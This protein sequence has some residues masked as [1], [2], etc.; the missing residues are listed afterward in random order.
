[1]FFRIIL[2]VDDPRLGRKLQRV[3]RQPDMSA[4]LLS[5]D[6]SWEE[7]SRQ[8]ADLL[9]VS[10]S[11]LPQPAADFLRSFRQIP[12]AP[13]VVILSEEEKA[14]EHARFLAAGCAAVLTSV[15]NVEKMRG[16]FLA[17]LEKRRELTLQMLAPAIGTASARLTDFVTASPTMQR[18]MD[19]VQRVV[20]KDTSLLI[21]GE[22]GVG[23]E[24][25]ARAI[26]AESPRSAGPFITVNCGAIPETLL[27]SE[28]FG[29][30]EGAFTGAIRARRGWFEL[31]H[32]GTVFLDEIGEL[33]YHLQVKLLRALQDHE[34]Q[35]LGSEKVVK[36]DV[37]VI[38]ATNRDLAAELEQNRFRKDLYYRL[39]VVTLA[40]PPLRERR[41]DVPMLIESYLSHL[42]AKIGGQ[43]TGIANE[44]V[45]ALM[46]YSWP[47]NVRELIN[48]IE[49]AML[50][51][52][53][54]VITIEDLPQA[55]KIGPRRRYFSILS[56][57]GGKQAPE[58][59]EEALRKPLGEVREAFLAEVER[60][61]LAGLL[62]QTRGRVG[63][64]A[65]RAGNRPRSLYDKMKKL[66]LRKEDF[67][68]L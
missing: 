53:G 34:I 10:H 29:H 66:G 14:V 42:R 40:M 20:N 58:L 38:A 12:D 61:Y 59:P 60:H 7:A 39:S 15:L 65:R 54:P 56:A 48:I 33:P 22:T 28:L 64:T 51:C 43:I 23:K 47:G 32:L 31:A 41:E 50:L 2:L 49:R 44:A 35:R 26:H 68:T 18:F 57:S 36:V 1:M 5:P 9:I 63:E 8:S 24:R 3:L 25:L 55:V 11:R 45:E 16:V 6:V 62:R 37:R 30:E 19:I 27:E 13:D 21:T 52:S 46:E 67:R 17:I 4:D